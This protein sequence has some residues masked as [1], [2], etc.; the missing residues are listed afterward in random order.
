MITLGATEQMGQMYTSIQKN[1]TIYQ[2][3]KLKAWKD[4]I[5]ISVLNYFNGLTQ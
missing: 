3:K 1:K 4:K 2:G 5:Q